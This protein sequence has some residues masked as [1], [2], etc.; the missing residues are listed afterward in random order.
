MTTTQDGKDRDLDPIARYRRS[1]EMAEQVICFP[2]PSSIGIRARTMAWAGQRGLE[3]GHQTLRL[4][5]SQAPRLPDSP[6]RGLRVRERR[7]RV[8]T[9]PCRQAHSTGL[10]E[11]QGNSCFG[12]ATLP[13]LVLSREQYEPPPRGRAWNRGTA[14]PRVPRTPSRPRCP[15][16][17]REAKIAKIA[18]SSRASV[19]GSSAGCR[20]R[21]RCPER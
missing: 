6:R 10:R 11:Q 5:V 3:A 15:P 16:P 2:S 20:P 19:P 12:S 9:R 14:R 21:G 4:S 17:A 8:A 7:R 1:G 18:D 13:C